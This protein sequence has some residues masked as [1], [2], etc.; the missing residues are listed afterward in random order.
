MTDRDQYI[1]GLRE[2]ADLLEQN[3]DFRLPYEGSTGNMTV[4]LMSYDVAD[5]K[6][7]M[8]E[9]TRTLRRHT[10][11]AVT[12]DA[13]SAYFDVNT[14]L[15]GPDG[16]S[17]QLSTQRAQVCERVVVGTEVKTKLVRDPELVEK[18][19]LVAV[20]EQEEIIEWQ[21]API[22]ASA[23]DDPVLTDEP[24]KVTKLTG[25]NSVSSPG[26]SELTS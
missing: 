5:P 1:A 8:A 18:L 6:V 9:H 3:P 2:L 26:P 15:G 21:C 14:R 7:A 11:E 13:T 23:A 4:F 22:L 25:P 10:R 12:K 24:G 17:V 16:L 19:P 20:E